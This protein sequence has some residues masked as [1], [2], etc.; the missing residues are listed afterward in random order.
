MTNGSAFT[1]GQLVWVQV[2]VAGVSGQGVPTGSVTI[3]DSINGG[4]TNTIGTVNLDPQG[5]GYLVAGNV[6]TSTNSC[7]YDYLFAQSPMLSG[8]SHSL[9]A[10]YS[11]DTTFQSPGTATPA[12]VTVTPIATT[13][14]LAAGATLITSGRHQPVR[15]I[16]DG[17]R[18]HGCILYTGS[19]RANRNRDL[20]RHNNVDRSWNGDR[21]SERHVCCGRQQCFPELDLRGVGLGVGYQYHDYRRQFDHGDLFG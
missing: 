13:P 21:C 18:S 3:T 5:N 8:G 1:Y 14:T 19:L 6:G 2:T 16:P 7:L 17:Y 15:S 9:S 10:T 4:P 12:T 20:H 11:G